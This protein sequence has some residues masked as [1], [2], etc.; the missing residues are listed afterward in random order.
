MQLKDWG[1]EFV[2]GVSYL[3]INNNPH[4]GVSPFILG[5]Y[6]GNEYEHSG[7]VKLFKFDVEGSDSVFYDADFMKDK[8]LTVFHS[9]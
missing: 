5:T 1:T 3:V 2:I 6:S 8:Y 7:Q 4:N 9:N